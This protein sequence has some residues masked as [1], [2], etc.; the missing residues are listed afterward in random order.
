MK[1]ESPKRLIKEDV[2]EED[3]ALV[4]KVGYVIN[5]S[6]EQLA[7]ILDNN[8]TIKDNFNQSQKEIIVTVN[9][10]GTPVT[11]TQFKTDISGNCRGL[12]V[13]NAVNQSSVNTYPTGTPFISFTEKVGVI[14]VNNITNLQAGNKYKLTVIIYP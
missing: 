7:K 8:L 14:T 10:T 2:Q 4:E 12:Q 5:P 1:F 3:R 6:F 11:A 9:A 13:I